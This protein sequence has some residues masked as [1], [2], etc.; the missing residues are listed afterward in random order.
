MVNTW[1]PIALHYTGL[2]CTGFGNHDTTQ[3]FFAR[4]PARR[5]EPHHPRILGLLVSAC[6][7]QKI[8]AF[9]SFGIL[10]V[11][12]KVVCLLY[13]PYTYNKTKSKYQNN[14]EYTPGRPNRRLDRFGDCWIYLPTYGACMQWNTVEDGVARD[15][16][17]SACFALYGT[18]KSR[19]V[20]TLSGTSLNRKG[21]PISVLYRFGRERDIHICTVLVW[22]GTIC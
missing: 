13:F 14:K 18:G 5:L 10:V 22:T 19:K 2:F 15:T 20:T 6:R 4:D 8:A 3:H 7:Q 1:T 9:F 21:I 12:H 17:I 11:L 16:T